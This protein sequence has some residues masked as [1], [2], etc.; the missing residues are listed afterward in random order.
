MAGVAA[1]GSVAD[2]LVA[3]LVVFVFTIA[4]CRT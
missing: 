3:F 1:F 2:T 4:A